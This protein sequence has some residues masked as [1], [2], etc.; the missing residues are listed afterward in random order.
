MP[1]IY[2]GVKEVAQA[3]GWD[4]AKVVMYKKRG[5]LVEPHGYMGETGKRPVWTKEQVERIIMLY[6]GAVD[7]E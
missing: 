2:Y 7:D 6:G 4:R 5:K 3:L 1:N